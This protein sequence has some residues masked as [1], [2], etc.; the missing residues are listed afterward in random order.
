MVIRRKYL[1]IFLTRGRFQASTSRKVVQD[2]AHLKHDAV[3]TIANTHYYITIF[4]STVRQADKKFPSIVCFSV[5]EGKCPQATIYRLAIPCQSLPS[6][7]H[8]YDAR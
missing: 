2:R 5:V 1:S 8:E 7:C 6:W 4:Y 3:E